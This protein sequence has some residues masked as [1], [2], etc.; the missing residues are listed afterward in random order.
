MSSPVVKHDIG[1]DV[2]RYSAMLKR[3]NAHLEFK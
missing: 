3:A 1:R 2:S